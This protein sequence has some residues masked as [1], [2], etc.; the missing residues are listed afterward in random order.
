MSPNYECKKDVWRIG[1][2]VEGKNAQLRYFGHV[3]RK[4][5]GEKVGIAMEAPMGKGEE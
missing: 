1:I 5:G 3:N 4:E 2:G